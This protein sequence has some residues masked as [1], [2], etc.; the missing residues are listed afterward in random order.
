MTANEPSVGILFLIS[1]PSGTGKSTLASKMIQAVPGI[2]FSISYTTR[3]P[4]SGETDGTEYHFVDRERF[5]RM[6]RDGQ[7]LEW[8]PV[9][10]QRYGTALKKTQ[11]ALARGTDVLLDVDVQGARQ[12]AQGPL[13]AV[14]IMILP[15]DY[16]TLRSRLEGRDSEGPESRIRRLKEARREAGAFEEFQYI[17]LNDDLESSV[18][19]LV[20]IVLAERQ[21][22]ERQTE[23]VRGVLATFPDYDA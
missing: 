6:V 19:A 9:F 15:P 13:P 11:E 7:F 10:D 4:R 21:R 17:I 2:E 20:S 18:T 22:R 23:A 12:V 1:A 14:T 5:D 16:E 8:A 3:G